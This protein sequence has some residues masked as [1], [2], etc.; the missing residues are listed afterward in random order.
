MNRS[1]REGTSQTLKALLALHP[2]GE[3]AAV[4]V[5]AEEAVKDKA[6]AGNCAVISTLDPEQNATSDPKQR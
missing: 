6:R 3:I 2:G 4:E 1:V 5:V